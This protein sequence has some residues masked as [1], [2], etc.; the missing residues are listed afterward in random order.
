MSGM[1]TISASMPMRM[2]A[3]LLILC[4]GAAAFANSSDRWQDARAKRL[5]ALTPDNPLAYLELA[6]EIADR[7][8]SNGSGD[9]DRALAIDLAAQAGALSMNT[10]GRSA[11]LFIA[12]VSRDS[13][14]RARMT[15][16]AQVL[17]GTPPTA[18]ALP[19]PAAVLGLA[20]AFSAYKRGHAARARAALDT[21]GTAALLDAHPEI[22][23]GGAVRFRADCASMKDGMA[24]PMT[25]AQTDALH[26]LVTAALKPGSQSWSESF[27]VNGRT[28]LP[29]FDL[30]DPGA[31]FGVPVTPAAP[32]GPGA[33]RGTASDTAPTP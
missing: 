5:A 19:D 33:T 14:Q 4:I 3:L 2:L 7:A 28:P 31:L 27:A 10:L 23:Q 16:L 25:A 26:A 11:A 20:Q 30:S 24:P 17:G 29:D 15:A 12:D 8:P 13:A 18:A 32:A 22:L 1:R 6:E 21:R 9:A